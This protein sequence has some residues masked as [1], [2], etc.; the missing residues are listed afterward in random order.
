MLAFDFNDNPFPVNKR[1]QRS[2]T[3]VITAYLYP[4]LAYNLSLSYLRSKN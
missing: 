1:L 4:S 3:I 2:Q